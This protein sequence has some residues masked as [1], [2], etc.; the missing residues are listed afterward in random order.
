MS[1]I[2]SKYQ[3]WIKPK[4]HQP[5]ISFHFI[6]TLS[7]SHF[8][9]C[10]TLYFFYI[11][12]SCSFLNTLFFPLP[13]HPRNISLP[14][15]PTISSCFIE[16]KF[17]SLYFLWPSSNIRH[18]IYPLLSACLILSGWTSPYFVGSSP[19]IRF[20]PWYFYLLSNI[21]LF[22]GLIQSQVYISNK[23]FCL[24]NLFLQ[25]YIFLKA[26]ASYIQLFPGKAGLPES[27]PD[28]SL[29]L[30]WHPVAFELDLT[31]IFFI[32]YPL[33]PPQE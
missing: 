1:K 17:F 31:W 28:S 19:L 4:F 3:Q 8:P 12:I 32:C 26:T 16:W 24:T 15:L 20:S 25:L 11:P 23:F 6:L 9:I 22:C 33:Q 29:T 10:C 2:E 5:Q 7:F 27:I 21:L 30:P 14:K 13:C 18:L